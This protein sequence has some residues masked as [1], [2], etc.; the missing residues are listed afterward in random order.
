MTDPS[1]D[2][3]ARLVQARLDGEITPEE[4][5]ALEQALAARPDL[6]D[7]EQRLR[8]VKR[9]LEQDRRSI[10]PPLGLAQRIVQRASQ[11]DAPAAV[12]RS[13]NRF[14]RPLAAAAALVLLLGASFY[15]GRESTSAEADVERSSLQEREIDVLRRHPEVDAAALKSLF[16]ATLRELDVIERRRAADRRDVM[17]RLELGIQALIRKADR[18]R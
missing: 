9:H 17:G 10:R 16:D 14:W 2:P 12:V 6:Q 8:D 18:P 15:L 5:R 13:S 1:I 4:E 3:M 11:E 7:L